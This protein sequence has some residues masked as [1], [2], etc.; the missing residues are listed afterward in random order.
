MIKLFL[1]IVVG[2]VVTII[3]EAIAMYVLFLKR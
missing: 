2:F 1:G 3:A